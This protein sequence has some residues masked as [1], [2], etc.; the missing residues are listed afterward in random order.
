MRGVAGFAEALP[1][2]LASNRFA[3]L[4]GIA[5]LELARQTRID[6]EQTCGCRL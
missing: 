1:V 3:S 4:Q 2:S 5:R 6:Y